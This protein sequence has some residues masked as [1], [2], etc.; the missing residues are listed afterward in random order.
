MAAQ[1]MAHPLV[2]I[3]QA[4]GGLRDPKEAAAVLVQVR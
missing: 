4:A 3:A 2:A 1:E